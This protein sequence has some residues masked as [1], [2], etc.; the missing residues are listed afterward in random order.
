[1]I[2]EYKHFFLLFSGLIEQVFKNFEYIHSGASPYISLNKTRPIF[3]QYHWAQYVKSYLFLP[4]NRYFVSTCII[5]LYTKYVQ[6]LLHLSSMND[7]YVCF[8]HNIYLYSVHLILRFYDKPIKNRFHV[9]FYGTIV[10]P[11]SFIV[12]FPI[13]I[14]MIKEVL[15]KAHESVQRIYLYIRCV[16]SACIILLYLL[17]YRTISIHQ[18]NS[19]KPHRR[20]HQVKRCLDVYDAGDVLMTFK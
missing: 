10:S 8:R 13:L 15:L 12:N 4:Q 1:M 20:T 11:Q 6:V 18:I 14:T 5:F 17:T 19:V 2:S 3:L 7:C 9:Y 16:T